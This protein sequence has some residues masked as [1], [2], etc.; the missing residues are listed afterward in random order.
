MLNASSLVRDKVYHATRIAHWYKLFL[1][2]VKKT[3]DL[4]LASLEV[5]TGYRLR[6]ITPTDKKEIMYYFYLCS[7]SQET[8]FFLRQY[9]KK[10]DF[11]S[12]F[13]SKT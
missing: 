5:V 4:E 8:P 1:L 13:Q 2:W 9:N 6:D 7:V 3:T 10:K 12:G 11:H